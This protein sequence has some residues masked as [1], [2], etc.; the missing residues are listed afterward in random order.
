MANPLTALE[1][2]KTH[3]LATMDAAPALP[4][5]ATQILLEP[6]EP[7]SMPHPAMIYL[8]LE[9]GSSNPDTYS[10]NA[11]RYLGTAYI[12]VRQSATNPGTEATTKAAM[13]YFAAFSNAVI[14][15]PTL[16]GAI[17][18]ASID[19]WDFYP[20]V[21]GLSKASGLEIAFTLHTTP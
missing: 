1:A 18:G 15:D 13:N 4:I 21:E 20:A 5:T 3:L 9:N 7:D 2:L 14:T 17:L 8:I 10:A 16:G 6:P 19:H 11:E 12:I